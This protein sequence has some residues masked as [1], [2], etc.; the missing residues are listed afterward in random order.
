[1]SV[2]KHV[3]IRA[4]LDQDL[5]AIRASA[6]QL[7]QIVMNLITNASDAIGDREGIIRV[8]TRPVTLKGEP[9]ASAS[10]TLPD[11]DYVQLEVSDTGCG[12]S[13][14][15][16]AKVFDPFF[17][18][19]ASG[20]GMGLAVVQGIVRSL[21]GAIRVTSELGKGTIFQILLPS[22]ERAAH[23]NGLED[24]GGMAVVP[25]QHGTVLVV[26]DEDHLR[27]PIVKMLRKTGFDVFEAA[28]GASAIARLRSDGD[29]VDVILLDLTIPGASHCE[30]IAEAARAKPNIGVILTSAYSQETIS[31]EVSQLPIRGF[32]RK[33][34]RF[35]DLLNTLR[36]AL[37]GSAATMAT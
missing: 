32:I 10:G 24:I 16:Q 31:D 2:T 11:G 34:F 25:T 5:P 13:P 18:T 20:R 17:T 6:A 35:Q 15:T 21:A 3:V 7:R 36:N 14:E 23:A 12:M 30:V 8:N 19:R 26:E 28:D 37:P 22:A 4:N 9:A 33:P 27:Q 1:V 29:R